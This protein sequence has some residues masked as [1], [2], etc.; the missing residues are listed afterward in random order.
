MDAQ[1][2]VVLCHGCFDLLHL[3]HIRHLEEAR[4][5]GDRLIVSVTADKHVG[6]GHGRPHFSAEQRREALAALS[7]VDEVV[8]TDGPTAVQAIERIRPA[9]YVK[10]GDYAGSRDHALAEEIAAVERCGGRF[11]VTAAEKWSS[12]LLLRNVRLSE[13]SQAYLARIDR[14]AFLDRILAAFE[15]ADR[16]RIVFAGETIVDEYRYVRPLAKPSKEFILATVSD[17]AE[18][19]EGG[20]VAAGKH[21]EWKNAV[22]VTSTAA[23]TKT[24]F[25]DA[26]FH[27]KL[28]EVYSTVETKHGVDH[29]E[30]LAFALEEADAV[31]AFDFGHGF[32]GALTTAIMQPSRYLAVTAQTNAGNYG[33]NPI[34]K[35]TGAHMVCVDEPEAHLAV[36]DRRESLDS[37]ATAIS[38]RTK[39]STVMITRGR[40]GS[41]AFNGKVAE[42]PAFVDGGL[43]TMGAGD[44]FLAVAA[45]LVAA[46]LPAEMAAFAGNV[47]GGLKT[48]IVGHRRH[49]GRDDVVKNVEWL[50]K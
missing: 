28:F 5:L 41:M 9:V 44:A 38:A 3:G 1:T 34:W 27:R 47:A 46:G 6:K 35:W 20:V 48:S 12:T 33:F 23:V 11:H 42:V 31:V 30:D 21:G 18:T 15:A 7:C 36:G 26:D 10:G 2:K 8:V 37:V 32:F 14:R 25:V 17:R 24:R 29:M 43:D 13:E 49:V 19:F 45:P 40:R 50:L 4:R 16:L 22:T 39:A